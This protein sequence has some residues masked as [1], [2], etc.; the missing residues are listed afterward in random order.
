MHCTGVCTYEVEELLK[1]VLPCSVTICMIVHAGASAQVV[2]LFENA[3][4]VAE[5]DT[6]PKFNVP[7]ILLYDYPS[8][9]KSHS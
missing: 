4:P 7:I 3:V 2:A 9:I 8:T 6:D 1:L 5:S